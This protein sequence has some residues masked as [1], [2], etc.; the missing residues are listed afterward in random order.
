MQSMTPEARRALQTIRR[1]VAT[2]RVRLTRHFRVRLTERGLVWPD[3]L[4]VI[5]DPQSVEADGHDEW[6]RP[7]W[8]VSGDAADGLAV[9]LVCVIGHDAAGK[10]TVF[11]TMHWDR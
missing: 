2:D 9:K 4:T 6:G 7:R 11:I 5:D 3:L 10:L 1:C 8:I